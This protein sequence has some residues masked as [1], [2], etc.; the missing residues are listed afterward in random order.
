MHPPARKPAATWSISTRPIPRLRSRTRLLLLPLNN[1]RS[2]LTLDASGERPRARLD[3]KVVRVRWVDGEG[4]RQEAW[5]WALAFQ[6]T[7]WVELE[8]RGWLCSRKNSG[9]VVSIGRLR[10][11]RPSRLCSVDEPVVVIADAPTGT[12]WQRAKK[13]AERA[14]TSS[15]SS[16]SCLRQRIITPVHQRVSPA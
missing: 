2:A 14:G 16:T 8:R 9:T 7:P 4:L 15:R 3:E 10:A 5:G 6:D 1:L 11:V 12:R 13:G